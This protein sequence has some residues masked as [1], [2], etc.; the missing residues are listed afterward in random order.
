[1]PII[2]KKVASAFVKGWKVA[3]KVKTKATFVKT[4]TTFDKTKATFDKSKAMISVF[5]KRH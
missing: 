3:Y 5:R 4:K 1:M 2:G